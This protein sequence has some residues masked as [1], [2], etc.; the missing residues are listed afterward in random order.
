MSIRSGN[1][2]VIFGV[3][4][5]HKLKVGLLVP[6]K[7]LLNEPVEPRQFLNIIIRI[8]LERDSH[9]IVLYLR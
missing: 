8:L 7:L 5:K 2:F 6:L 1:G 3:L 9:C 4:F